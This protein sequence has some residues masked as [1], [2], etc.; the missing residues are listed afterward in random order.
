M[1]LLKQL[2][3]PPDLV[4]RVFDVVLILLQK[5]IVPSVAVVVETKRGAVTQ[6]DR[7]TQQNAALVEESAAAAESLK[8]QAR[9][10]TEVISVFRTPAS[11]HHASHAA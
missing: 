10:L 7:M 4:K 3:K 11:S 8:A 5:D 1:S 6:L 9:K 2:K